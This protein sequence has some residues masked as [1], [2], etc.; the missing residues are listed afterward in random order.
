M[1]QAIADAD[2]LGR[3]PQRA[4]LTVLRNRHG[5]PSAEEGTELARSSTLVGT[6]VDDLAHLALE[7]ANRTLSD[8]YLAM[9]VETVGQH[10]LLPATTSLRERHLL[11]DISKSTGLVAMQWIERKFSAS[12]ESSNPEAGDYHV[13]VVGLDEAKEISPAL[14]FAIIL[15]RAGFRSTTVSIG[16]DPSATGELVA[17]V[18]P[19]AVVLLANSQGGVL[20]SRGTAGKLASLRDAGEWRGLVAC[21]GLAAAG[22]PIPSALMLGDDSLD[23]PRALRRALDNSHPTNEGIHDTR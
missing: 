3:V 23:A 15:S 18:Q 14:A 5:S 1:E 4:P 17:N 22:A 12:Y 7:R 10:V 9:P 8:A 2:T 20:A 16:S 21:Q 6:L 13:L 19:D 11:G